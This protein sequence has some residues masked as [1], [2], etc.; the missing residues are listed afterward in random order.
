MDDTSQRLKRKLRRLYDKRTVNQIL[1]P[2]STEA[3]P[4]TDRPLLKLPE[5]K[6]S[7][8]DSTEAPEFPIRFSHKP[9]R[10]LPNK[11]FGKFINIPLT[12]RAAAKYYDDTDLR[13]YRESQK[14]V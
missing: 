2:K 14:D 12:A 11:K 13:L 9:A 7:N 6:Q 4:K 8:E 1:Q 3:Y 10:M 5:R